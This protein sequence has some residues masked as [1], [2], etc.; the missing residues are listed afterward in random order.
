MK[1]TALYG[2][3]PGF[4]HGLSR[5]NN[6]IFE[7]F[8]ELGETVAEIS[9][10]PLELPFYDGRPAAEAEKIIGELAVSDGVILSFAT[11]LS[12]PCSVMQI[13]LEHLSADKFSSC[14]KNKNIFLITS[15]PDYGEAA[16]LSYVSRVIASLGGY[17][18]VSLGVNNTLVESM[19]DALKNSIEKYAEDY[20]RVVRQNRRFVV[21]GDGAPPRAEK[22]N[23]ASIKNITR[24]DASALNGERRPK[25]TAAE[26]IKNIDMD[27]FTQKQE[28]DI[29]EIT[30]YFANKYKDDSQKEKPGQVIREPLAGN[31]A[32]A[33][34]LKTCRQLTQN[35]IHYYQPQLAGDLNAVIQFAIAGEENF[36]GY[37]AVSNGE[38]EYKDGVAGSPDISILCDSSVWLDVLK[39]RF[40]AQK[41]FM[42]GRLKVRGN[43]VLLTKFDQIFKI[44]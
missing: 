40:T 8:R 1:L 34:R 37:L 23:S 6:I 12:A 16:S 42:T 30:Q 26:L 3:A 21:P 9:L 4:D 24:D 43:F 32:P 11:C 44:T 33:P 14:F 15:S 18:A 27:S 2:A 35:L 5:V 41:A 7:T 31:A 13:F 10:G 29:D 36:D 22:N 19:D 39:G 38:C 17:C 20:Y 25:V 28:Q